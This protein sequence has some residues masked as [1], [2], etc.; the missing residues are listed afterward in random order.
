MRLSGPTVAI[1]VAIALVSCASPAASSTAKPGWSKADEQR[2][3]NF[4]IGC[5][6]GDRSTTC[7]PGPGHTVTEGICVVHII[8]DRF[9]TIAAFD[10]LSDKDFTNEIVADTLVCVGLNTAAP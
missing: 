9:A 3:I 10:A 2:V 5:A 4:V 7:R 8:E 6:G 1:A